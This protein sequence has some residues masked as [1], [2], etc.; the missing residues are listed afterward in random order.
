MMSAIK[1]DCLLR[2]CKNRNLN[3]SG[4][5]PLAKGK[6]NELYDLLDPIEPISNDEYKVLYFSVG[7]V[8]FK[9]YKKVNAEE[10]LDVK[11]MYQYYKEDYPEKV[12]YYKLISTKYRNFRTISINTTNI[13]CS[14]M[15]KKDYFEDYWLCELLDFLIIKVRECVKMLKRGTYNEYINNNYSYRS[16]FGVI[17]RNDY[18]KLYPDTYDDLLNC[19]SKEEI[20]YFLDNVGK[21]ETNRIKDMTAGKYY[22]CVGLIYKNLGYEIEGRSDKELYLK[23]ADGRDEGLRDIDEN[24]PSEFE[25][26]YTNREHCGGHPWEILRGHSFYRV[27]VYPEKDENGYYIYINGRTILRKIEIAL[28]FNVFRKNNIPIVID[29][30]EILTEAFKGND[31]LG[32]VP[33]FVLPLMCHGY[34]KKYKPEEFLHLEVKGIMDY[35]KWEPLAEVKLKEDK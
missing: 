7:N 9:E 14:D 17:K 30:Y 27:N 2:T 5:G 26:W 31:Y 12:K 1:F 4:Y 20:D 13:I 32:I 3:A 29:D 35:I 23:Y 19:I 8:N 15:D 16:R 33:S 24:N 6:I 21:K 18:W 22:N 28:I 11:E 10:D 34:Y 25:N